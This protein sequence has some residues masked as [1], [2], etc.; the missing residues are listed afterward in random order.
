MPDYVDGF[1]AG[2]CLTVAATVGMVAVIVLWDDICAGFRWLG[3]GLLDFGAAVR[4]LF[5][6]TI[7]IPRWLQR[8][9]GRINR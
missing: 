1:V 9:L 4:S 7:T 3:H 2:V 6:P 5:S 8:I